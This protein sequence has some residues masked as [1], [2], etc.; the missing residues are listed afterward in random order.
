MVLDRISVGKAHKQ[1]DLVAKFW[2]SLVTSLLVLM[3]YRISDRCFRFFSTSYMGLLSGMDSGLS[4][5]PTWDLNNGKMLN[6]SVS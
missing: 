3:Y 6:V 1:A 2:E 4:A 5:S